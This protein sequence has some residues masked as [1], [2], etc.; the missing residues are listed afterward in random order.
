MLYTLPLIFH[1]IW[2]LTWPTGIQQ[3]EFRPILAVFG[4]ATVGAI[5][6]LAILLLRSDMARDFIYF[7]F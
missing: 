7:Q 2:D 3:N 1:T 4:N 5:M 6:L